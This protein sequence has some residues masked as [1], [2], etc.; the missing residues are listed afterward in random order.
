M[1]PGARY[2]AQTKAVAV[3]M[4]RVNGEAL[5]DAELIAWVSGLLVAIFGAAV[6]APASL[7][8]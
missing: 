7:V 2:F 8:E 6:V 3:P 4:P 1:Y 5:G